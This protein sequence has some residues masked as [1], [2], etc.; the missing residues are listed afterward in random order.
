M[1]EP[2]FYLVWRDGGSLPVK[3]H[4]SIISAENEAERLA[5]DN[6]GTDFY[7]LIPASRSVE[8]RVSIER[9][10]VLASDVPF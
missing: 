9:F 10:D 5:R 7:V 2:P 1:N 8:R 3:Q 6:P 4:K